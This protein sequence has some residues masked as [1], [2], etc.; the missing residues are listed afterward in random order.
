[1]NPTDLSPVPIGLQTLLRAAAAREAGFTLTASEAAILEATSADQLR[2]MAV[3]S[4]PEGA[5]LEGECRALNFNLGCRHGQATCHVRVVFAVIVDCTCL[6]QDELGRLA[7][8]HLHAPLVMGPSRGVRDEVSIG[9][10]DGV[11]YPRLRLGRYEGHVVDGDFYG[12][13]LRRGG[14]QP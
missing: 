13:R 3:A 8:L 14:P 9:P 5:P 7:S 1:M 2:R 6:L 10:Y 11:T 4:P 12:R